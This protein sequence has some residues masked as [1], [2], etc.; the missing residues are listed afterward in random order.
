MIVPMEKT[1]NELV[2][3]YK[4]GDQSAIEALVTRHLPAV[5]NF[6]RRFA[7]EEQAKDIAQE[8]FV[9]VWKHIKR[10]DDTRNFRVWLFT[11]AKRAAID[12]TRKKKHTPFSAFE[13]DGEKFDVEDLSPLPDELFRKDEIA[14]ALGDLIDA[15]PTD[16]KAIVV[17][18]DAEMLSFADIAVIMNRPMNTVKSQYRRALMS[19][20]GMID[21]GD[22]P[23]L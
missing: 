14:K 21:G 13:E 17:L 8:T 1:D 7:D 16:R 3:A 11:I 19:L 5:Y 22:A 18:H 15:L 2:K 9:K 4:A 12:F 10:Y 20:R 6:V 23:K